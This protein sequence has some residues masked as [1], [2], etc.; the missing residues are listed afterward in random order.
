MPRRRPNDPR[1]IRGVL[2]PLGTPPP[3]VASPRPSPKTSGR[4][5]RERSKARAKMI[6]LVKTARFLSDAH[7]VA[8]PSN[9][10]VFF[11]DQES[12]APGGV[13]FYTNVRSWGTT[14]AMARALLRNQELGACIMPEMHGADEN[15]GIHL[16]KDAGHSFERWE[17]P[18]ALPL[19]DDLLIAPTRELP[20]PSD[21]PRNLVTGPIL[22]DQDLCDVP[23]SRQLFLKYT[24]GRDESIGDGLLKAYLDADRAGATPAPPHFAHGGTLRQADRA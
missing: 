14:H 10:A 15:F 6:A 4:L 24:G 11:F 12:T 7:C 16:E 3:T 18:S 9:C 1:N 17:A 22:L 21:P 20:P 5:S 23:T 13:H 8:V 2:P 19:P